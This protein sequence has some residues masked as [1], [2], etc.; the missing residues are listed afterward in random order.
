[1]T[2]RTAFI[3]LSFTLCLAAVLAGCAAPRA[4]SVAPD[5][6]HTAPAVTTAASSIPAPAATVPPTATL[7][8]TATSV[9]PT[10][11]AAPSPTP[12]ATP[13]ASSSSGGLP[14]DLKVASVDRVTT[15]TLGNTHSEAHAGNVYL[16]VQLAGV[17]G[18]TADNMSL[19]SDMVLTDASGN[20]YPN[21]GLTSGKFIFEVPNTAKGLK[22]VVGDNVSAPLP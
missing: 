4:A 12:T 3:Q 22:L 21:L 20:R 2:T 1:M 10:A 6:L 19:L 7:V 17:A 8:P 15:L 14:S 11:T 16:L 18:L 5:V 13:A 9:P